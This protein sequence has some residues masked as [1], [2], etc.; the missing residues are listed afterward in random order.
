MGKYLS[1]LRRSLSAERFPFEALPEVCKMHVFSYLNV[2]DRVS[3]S[4]VC[5]EWNQLIKS[6]ALWVNIDVTEAVRE[7]HRR[8]NQT[9]LIRESEHRVRTI[10]FLSYISTIRPSIRR[11]V[12]VGD[13]ADRDFNEKIQTFARRSKLLELQEVVIDWTRSTKAFELQTSDSLVSMDD[14]HRRRQ[15]LFVRFFELLARSAPNLKSIDLPFDWSVNSVDAIIGLSKL[16]SVTFRRYSDLQTL[17]AATLDRMISRMPELRCLTVEVWT[18]CASGGLTYFR[19][20]SDSLEFVDL[21][22]CRGV[23]ISEMHL[24]QARVLYISRRP[25]SGPLAM[26]NNTGMSA[27]PPPPCLYRLL[28][29]GAP[30]LMQLNEHVLQN[31]WQS[32]VYDELDEILKSVCPCELHCSSAAVSEDVCM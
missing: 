13:I 17:D 10:K 26:L 7:S 32:E 2:A 24:P 28:V 25:W 8:Q 6:A 31:N 19:L 30:S 16:E 5:K 9:F 1:K 18:P 20:R 4:M 29:S 12:L 23:A 3:V 14:N 15:R 22:E 11:L 21:S 27:V